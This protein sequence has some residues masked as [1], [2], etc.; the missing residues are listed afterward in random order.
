MNTILGN[1][2]KNKYF[3]LLNLFLHVIYIYYFK[4]IIFD[5][6]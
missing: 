4:Y 6:I 5:D 3:I 2:N 1:K